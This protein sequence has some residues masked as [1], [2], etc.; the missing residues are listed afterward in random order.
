[1]LSFA[2]TPIFSGSWDHRP[3][4]SSP[5]SSSPVR[6]SSPLS[7]ISDNTSLPRLSQSSPLQPSK[8]KYSS[9]PTRPNPLVRRREE[10]QNSRRQAFLQ[11]VRQ[12]ADDKAWARRDVEGQLVK[13]SIL[14]NRIELAHGAPALTDDDIEDAETYER[15]SA[16]QPDEDDIMADEPQDD[17]ELEAMIAAYEAEQVAPRQTPSSLAWSDDDF[18]DAFDDYLAPEPP[19]HQFSHAAPE[20][21]DTS[22]DIN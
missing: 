2:P 4:V 16:Q 14:A 3:V 1:M 18:D 22:G 20:S 12:K 15:H 21:M 17:D 19:S 8:F 9:R 11:N 6:A 10:A 7:P 13:T 5:L